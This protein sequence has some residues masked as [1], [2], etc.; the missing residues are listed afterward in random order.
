MD[1]MTVLKEARRRAEL[2]QRELALLAGVPQSTVGRIESGAS[3]PRASTLWALLKACGFEL[4]VAA[5]P[6]QGVDPTQIR[7]L[8]DLSPRQ[9]LDACVVTAVNVGRMLSSVKG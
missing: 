6:G 2:T 8:L 3:D 7:E 5:R 9:R 1:A 4:R